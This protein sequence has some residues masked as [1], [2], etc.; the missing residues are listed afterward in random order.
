MEKDSILDNIRTPIV[1]TIYKSP[2]EGLVKHSKKIDECVLN[3]KECIYSYLECDF[4]KAEEYTRNVKRIEHEAD[5]IKANTRA[6]IPKSIFFA[7]SKREFLHLLHDSDSILDYAEDVAVLLTMKRTRVPEDVADGLKELI[8]KVIECVGSYLEV[9]SHMETLVKVS[10]GGK[11]R[12]LV[13]ELIKKIHQYEHEADTLEFKISKYL[14]NIDQEILDPI[15]VLH[16]LKVVDRMGGIADKA[17]NAGE[18][19]RAMLAK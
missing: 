5:M 15:S 7:V 17:Q 18:R 6:H 16:L 10:F 11:E 8:D 14:F 19:V 1:D 13:K 3:I 4:E 2:F 9:M 12:D